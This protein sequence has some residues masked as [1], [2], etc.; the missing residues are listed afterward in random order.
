MERTQTRGGPRQAVI[1]AALR[2]EMARTGRSLRV[3]DVG[4]GTGGFAV[5][6]ARAGHSVTVIDPSPDA[7]AAAERR[8]A[9]AGVAGLITARQGDADSLAELVEP[10]SVDLVLCHTVLEVVDDPAKVTAALA[11]VLLPGGA[12]SVVVVNRAAAVL[13]KAVAGQIDAAEQLLDQAEG[14]PRRYDAESAAEL[15]RSAGLTVEKLH[16]V[17]VIADLIPGALA[18]ADPEGLL[19]FEL[20]V[21]GLAPYRDIAT[22]LHLFARKTA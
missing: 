12:A 5:P 13:A 20:A 1:W 22:Q 6:L 4:G 9:E 7:L 14:T 21:S 11:Q 17:R 18:D 15:L 2:E 3:V 16:G 8:A 10:A 19:R